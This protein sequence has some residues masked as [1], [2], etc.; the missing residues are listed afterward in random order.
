MRSLFGNVYSGRRVLI[1]GHTGFKGSWLCFW[2]TIL[3]AE[4]IGFSLK[5]PSKPDLFSILKIKENIIHNTG[6]IRNAGKFIDL[7][8]FYKPEMIFHFAAQP[9]VKLSYDNPSLTYSSNI[10]GTINL[11]EALRQVKFVKICI[12]AA[13]DKCYHEN[14]N[15][16]PFKENDPLGGG[17]DHYSTSK[18]CVELIVNA[19]KK[20]HDF[21]NTSIS[22][23]RSGNVI[24]G[25]DWG[26]SRLIPDCIKAV[27]ENK[28]IKIRNIKSIRPWIYILDALSGY[29][30][31]GSMMTAHPEKFNSSW[32][33]GPEE[34]NN[35]YTTGYIVRKIIELSGRGKIKLEKPVFNESQIL[36]INSSRIRHFLKWDTLYGLDRSIEKTVLWYKEYYNKKNMIKYSEAELENYVNTAIDNKVVWTK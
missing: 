4:V 15:G 31:L 8:K 27:Q 28:L 16:I 30:C 2:L 36:K 5:P 24:G 26:E 23:V 21:K 25:G 7:I 10:T 22:T 18:A 13:S 11:L 1:T 9:I 19:Y 14:E 33:L 34:I 3:G 35:N 29:L 20:S 6:D 32:N 17:G 12:I